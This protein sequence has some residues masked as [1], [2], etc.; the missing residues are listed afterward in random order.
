MVSLTQQSI[1][2]LTSV[3]ANVNVDIKT[4]LTIL[5]TS[6]Y[7]GIPGQY[8]AHGARISTWLANLVNLRIELFQSHGLYVQQEIGGVYCPHPHQ[9]K[10][11]GAY[12]YSEMLGCIRRERAESILSSN[13]RPL[14]MATLMQSR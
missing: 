5:N 3:D 8:I 6:C 4:A 12:R 9:S 11:S 7:R 1:R 13:Q 2:T 10:L 14:S